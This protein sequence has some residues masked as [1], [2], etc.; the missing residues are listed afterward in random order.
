MKQIGKT[1]IIYDETGKLL[2]ASF[3]PTVSI[4]SDESILSEMKDISNRDV[5]SIKSN[6]ELVFAQ[7]FRKTDNLI[8]EIELSDREEFHVTSEIEKCEKYDNG[9]VK[10]CVIAFSFGPRT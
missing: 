10:R 7:W 3:Q 9:S 1:T 5:E 6:A 4:D 2:S 8:T